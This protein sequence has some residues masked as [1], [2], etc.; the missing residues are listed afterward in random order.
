MLITVAGNTSEADEEAGKGG[1]SAGG[2]ANTSRSG[3]NDT[4]S[5]HDTLRSNVT[6]SSANSGGSHRISPSSVRE[7]SS[8]SNGARHRAH[9]PRTAAHD[10]IQPAQNEC[11]QPGTMARRPSS[12]TSW[13]ILHGASG[14]E[15]A[16]LSVLRSGAGSGAGADSRADSVQPVLELESESVMVMLVRKMGCWGRAPPW[17]RNFPREV[18]HTP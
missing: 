17:G 12:G 5:I 14:G 13:H 1:I 11:R 8:D 18:Q 6:G 7:T 4:V 2:G 10:T 16:I 3:S 15:S 9:A